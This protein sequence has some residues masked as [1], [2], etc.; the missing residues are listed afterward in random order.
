MEAWSGSQW[1]DLS[2]WVV[3]K[4]MCKARARLVNL[5][6]VLTRTTRVWRGA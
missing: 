5:A 3:N 1:T 4:L 6:A 2:Q